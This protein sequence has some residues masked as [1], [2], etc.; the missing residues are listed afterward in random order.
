LDIKRADGVTEEH[1]PKDE[2][3]RGRA[4]GL[5]DNPADVIRRA[6]QVTEYNRR[7]PPVRDEREHHAADDDHLRR[8]AKARAAPTSSARYSR[9]CH[10]GSTA[11]DAEERGEV[12]TD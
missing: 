1:D 8:A 3:R 2:P 5:L 4:D 12:I 10:R 7:R 9:R 11:E 6:R